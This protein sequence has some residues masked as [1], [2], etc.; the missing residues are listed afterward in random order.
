MHSIYFMKKHNDTGEGG[1][2][3]S[4]VELP[5]TRISWSPS[6]SYR[7]DSVDLSGFFSDSVYDLEFSQRN[8]QPEIG[9]GK[10]ALLVRGTRK[11]SRPK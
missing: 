10:N 9:F 2:G 3:T 5:T 1:E 7:R 4:K 8:K 6:V 11:L